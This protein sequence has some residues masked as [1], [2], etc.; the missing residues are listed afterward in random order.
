MSKPALKASP[1]G[2]KQ[3]QEAFTQRRF[4]QES[5]AHHLGCNRSV[6]SKFFNGE[7][8][9]E[10]YFTSICQELCLDWQKVVSGY[11]PPLVQEVRS[12]VRELIQEWCGSMRI[13]DMTQPIKLSQIYTHVNILEKLTATRRKTIE[14]LLKECEYEDFDRFGLGKVVEEKVPGV[15]AVN[16]YKKLIVLGKPGAGKTTFLKY[17]AIQCNQGNFQSNL[18]PIFIPLK[19]FAE[20]SDKPS[21]FEYIKQQYSGCDVTAEQF[22][23]LFKHGLALILLDGLDEVSIEHQE[24]ILKEVRNFSRIFFENHY[25]ITCRI[26]AW[27]YTFDKFIEVEVADFDEHQVN[28]FAQHWFDSKLVKSV[29]FIKCLNGNNR[30]YQL[31]VTPLLLTLLCLVFEESGCLPNNRSELY[32]EGLYILLKK[33][34]AKRGIHRDEFYEKMSPTRKE[35][36]LSRIAF[37]TFENYFFTPA[38]VKNI[39]EKYLSKIS[40]HDNIPKSQVDVEELLNSIESQH[41]LVI[42]RAKGIY[43][44]SHIT[45][46][47]YFI[48]KRIV[49]LS[50][51]LGDESLQDEESLNTKELK[52]LVKQITNPK[53][54]QV[55]LLV[56]EM[57]PDAEK[58]FLLIKQKADEILVNND[59]LQHY[60]GDVNEKTESLQHPFEF[61]DD[62]ARDRFYTAM[63]A[64]YFDI[65]YEIDHDR[66]LCI[67]LDV[68]AKYLICGNCF[69]RIFKD[70]N[71]LEQGVIEAKKYDESE[72]Q[73][74]RDAI[75]AD[76]IVKIAVE[77]GIKSQRIRQDKRE[78]LEEIQRNFFDKLDQTQLDEEILKL[79]ADLARN[80]ARKAALDTNLL[81][82][83]LHDFSQ[84]EQKLLKQY[85]DANKLLLD[86]L[87]TDCFVSRKVC[88]EIIKTL[89]LPQP[90]VDK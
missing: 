62:S 63:R 5:L 71:N 14:E 75:S 56:A 44:F 45:F 4:T 28:E 60:L 23:Y 70:I 77:Y 48:A 13:L 27:D 52:N 42:E 11:V 73:K 7:S 46:H 61:P 40:I 89:F 84:E 15:D 72:P 41:G 39:V 43:S 80:V 36:L 31:A 66:Q 3:A 67:T 65:D 10:K 25:I 76:E 32:R 38:E 47:E 34:D 64:F 59:K 69:T 81:G 87:R 29:D 49:S 54:R 86:C 24:R 6:I 33:W 90:S 79:G 9:W 19:Y 57:L 30:A 78:E 53:W 50:P 16:K 68:H 58:L 18:V 74:I 55:F 17:L 85:Y 22:D 12:K 2:V 88:D 20:A 82:S 26:A 21:L 8:I 37:T 83:G 51:H 1:E 35:D